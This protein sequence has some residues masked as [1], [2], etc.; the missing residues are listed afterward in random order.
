M[1]EGDLPPP[2]SVW[3]YMP[4]PLP[5]FPFSMRRGR[6]GCLINIRKDRVGGGGGALPLYICIQIVYALTN[7]TFLCQSSSCWCIGLCTQLGSNS[8]PF[9]T[10][11]SRKVASARELQYLSQPKFYFF[12]LFPT[13]LEIL[14]CHVHF[15]LKHSTKFLR[16]HCISMTIWFE[17][18]AAQSKPD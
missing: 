12:L 15:I 6:G 8:G 17:D 7:T 2:M 10:L 1:R 18:V 9:Y 5:S 11:A 14:E 4:S 13:F 16:N 3:R